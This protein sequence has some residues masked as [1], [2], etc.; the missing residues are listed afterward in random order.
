MLYALN[1][2]D[3]Q[4]CQMVEVLNPHLNDKVVIACERMHFLDDFHFDQRLDDIVNVRGF[5]LH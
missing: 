5:G 2:I 1:P 4:A 3:D